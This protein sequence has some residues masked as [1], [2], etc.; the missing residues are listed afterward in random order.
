[1]NI[2]YLNSNDF[3]LFS[4]A[5]EQFDQLIKQLQSEEQSNFDT[6]ES[7]MKVSN[8]S[9]IVSFRRSLEMVWASVEREAETVIEE[10]FQEALQ[11]DLKQKRK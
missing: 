4:D 1:M 8:E 3:S 10:A 2:A 5:Q 9:N 6:A 11:R 7:I